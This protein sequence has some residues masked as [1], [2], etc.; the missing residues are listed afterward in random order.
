MAAYDVKN[1][2]LAEAGKTLR[3]ILIMKT[4]ANRTETIRECS[5][6]MGIEDMVVKRMELVIKEKE[7]RV[8]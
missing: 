6:I 3:N 5:A 2:H 7:M 4:V 1:D 8:L